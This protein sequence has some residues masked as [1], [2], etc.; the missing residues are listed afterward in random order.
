MISRNLLPSI[1]GDNFFI[2]RTKNR[3]I[4][5]IVNIF[6]PNP[7]RVKKVLQKYSLG[8]QGRPEHIHPKYNAPVFLFKEHFNG[9]RDTPRY[10]FRNPEQLL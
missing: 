10:D 1:R 4:T 2:G 6:H 3:D 7:E 8:Q 5:T 9:W